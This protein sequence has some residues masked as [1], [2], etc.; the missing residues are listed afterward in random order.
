MDMLLHIVIICCST[1][2]YVTVGR[3]V[4]TSFYHYLRETDIAE[5]LKHPIK[6]HLYFSSQDT[7]ES[8]L[9]AAITKWQ[10]KEQTET[11]LLA[12]LTGLLWPLVGLGLG[13]FWF[14]T[15][16]PRL[17][18]ANPDRPTKRQLELERKKAE[19]Q[20]TLRLAERQRYIT[21]LEAENERL[22][23]NQEI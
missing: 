23:Q 15:S 7:E 19:R 16:L 3:F 4:A 2:A 8:R 14:F 17:F 12:V 5:L 22:R 11:R 10:E 13:C 21:A 6:Y 18:I 20:N 1:A 9:A